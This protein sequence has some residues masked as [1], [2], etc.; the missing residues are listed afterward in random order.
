M[1]SKLQSKRRKAYSKLSRSNKSISFKELFK[2]ANLFGFTLRRV[3]GSHH[4]F[5]REDINEKLNI[6][7]N[8]ND[9]NK[10]KRYQVKQLL[11]IINTYELLENE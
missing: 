1:D 4:L 2:M 5:K 3:K 8:P 7:K 10:A 11:N 6:Q 9:K